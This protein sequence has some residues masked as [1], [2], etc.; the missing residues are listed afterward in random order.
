MKTG[1]KPVIAFREDVDTWVYFDQA[2]QVFR[3]EIFCVDYDEWGCPTTL[4]FVIEEGIVSSDQFPEI[5]QYENADP[6]FQG[7]T[8]IA[9]EDKM[10][11]LPQQNVNYH[12]L[13]AEKLEMIEQQLKTY[14]RRRVTDKLRHLGYDVIAAVS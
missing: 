9:W 14:S 11:F 13:V 5:G 6:H 2:F 8:W 4:S 7:P 1:T 3:Y 12:P 10:G